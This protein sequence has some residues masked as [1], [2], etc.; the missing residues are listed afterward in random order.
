MHRIFSDFTFITQ[1]VRTDRNPFN[2][3]I[4]LANLSAQKICS[5]LIIHTWRQ[6]D[7]KKLDNILLT[8]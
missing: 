7:T 2:R 4:I 8:K 1:I 5:L 3:T 6:Q